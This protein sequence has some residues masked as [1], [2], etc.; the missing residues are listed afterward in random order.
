MLKKPFKKVATA[1]AFSPNIEAN[2]GESIRLCDSLGEELLLIHVGDYSKADELRL[3][4]IIQMK[5]GDANAINLV[6][7]AGDPADVLLKV[8]DENG[9][10][11]LIAGAIPK[12]GLLRYYKGSIARKLVRRANCSILLMVN[13]SQLK[14]HCG[15][16]VVNGIEHPKTPYTIKTAISVA[17]KLEVS[18]LVI[19]EEVSE[20][21]INTRIED[22]SS[23]QKSQMIQQEI[24][25]KEQNRIERLLYEL[26]YDKSLDIYQN[27]VFGKPGYCINHFA[28]SS[29]ADL[30]IMNSPDTKLGL[31]DRVFTHDLE[32]VLS[33]LPCDLLIVHSQ[34]G[35]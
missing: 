29:C 24:E 26:E 25:V 35:S 10:D 33:E 8:A 32:Y 7:E 4:E 16:I 30:L 2:I 5:G 22:D 17:D 1:V 3:L 31:L 14:S 11:L 18:E 9:V 13:P 12:E 23:L 27:V 20:R 34:R 6:W 21:A 28:E 19:V 15:K